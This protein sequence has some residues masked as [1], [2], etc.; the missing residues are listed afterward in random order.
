MEFVKPVLIEC[1]QRGV[2]EL[3]IGDPIKANKK[4]TMLRRRTLAEL[5]TASTQGNESC[6]RLAQALKA[7]PL[8]FRGKSVVP[9]YCVGKTG[10]VMTSKPNIQGMNGH[11]RIAGLKSGLLEGQ[12]LVEAD[13][14]S[15]DPTV[16][17]FVLGIPMERD[18]YAEYMAATGADR[19]T[20]KKQ[21]NMLAYS[22]N[23]HGC[24]HHMPDPAKD[25]LQDYVSALDDYRTKLLAE[26]RDRRGVAT[27]TGRFMWADPGERLHAGKVLCWRV[28]GTVADIINPAC[29]RLMDTAAAVIP[30]HDAILAIMPGGRAN[31]VEEAIKDQ[32][33]KIG[34]SVKV[35]L[36]CTA[37]STAA[38][39]LK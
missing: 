9:T 36:S 17:K 28:Q 31:S 20:A 11:D 12:E 6:H 30:M 32:A 29:L 4:A 15:A 22:K 33:H 27:L 26:A 8:L 18:F 39:P 21:V 1:H 37:G 23:L 5:K 24:F 34:L 14:A 16:I 25:A 10:R 7:Q 3:E 2:I 19:S 38:T 35:K 13:I